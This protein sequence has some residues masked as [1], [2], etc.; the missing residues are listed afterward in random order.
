MSRAHH[1]SKQLEPLRREPLSS[2]PGAPVVYPSPPRQTTGVKADPE[3]MLE[4]VR[5]TLKKLR[6][7]QRHKDIPKDQAISKTK[8][9]L[10]LVRR[11]FD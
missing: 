9:Y 6:T 4:S 1:A 11:R 7:L 8:K 10:K 2:S 3:K 5:V